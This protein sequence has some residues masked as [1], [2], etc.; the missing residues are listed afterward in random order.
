VVREIRVVMT[1]DPLLGGYGQWYC[2]R[3]HFFVVECAAGQEWGHVCAQVGL[4]P[5]DPDGRADGTDVLCSRGIRLL[6][7][8]DHFDIR[9]RYPG[10]SQKQDAQRLEAERV[11][12]AARRELHA[13]QA[14]A[15]GLRADA[16]AEA[17]ADLWEEM[18][19]GPAGP[20]P[21]EYCP[22]MWHSL[23][24]GVDKGR[25]IPRNRFQKAADA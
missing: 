17:V 21:D 12:A 1:G 16:P 22:G 6:W 4:D 15:V 9:S 24:V 14:A 18:G 11:A 5:D 23:S 19:L 10:G 3:R 13:R 25:P 7:R 8:S 2:W 20:A